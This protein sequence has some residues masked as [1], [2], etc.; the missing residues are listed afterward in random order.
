MLS[1]YLIVSDDG[2]IKYWVV[3]G[4]ILG[5]KW[6][7][8]IREKLYSLAALFH[9]R[10]IDD[11]RKPK[12]YDV[13]KDGEKSFSSVKL[14]DS[15]FVKEEATVSTNLF[16][17]FAFADLRDVQDFI[18]SCSRS[19]YEPFKTVLDSHQNGLKYKEYKVSLLMPEL[20]LVLT[21]GYIPAE[22]EHYN[23]S[24]ILFL[25]MCKHD[26]YILIIFSKHQHHIEHRPTILL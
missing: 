13:D 18:N 21:T 2:L 17:E 15:E 16:F 4:S 23:V 24:M 11:D 14:S 8:G 6:S 1:F 3:S 9:A 19:P 22:N 5:C 20:R 25:D 12:Y 7:S 10:F 26:I